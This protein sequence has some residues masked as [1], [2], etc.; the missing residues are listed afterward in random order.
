MIAKKNL[1]RQK[2]SIR[3][4]RKEKLAQRLRS[5]AAVLMS[6]FS[7]FYFYFAL[8]MRLFAVDPQ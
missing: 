1:M 2:L 6:P 4:R 5:L 3:W 7:Q 8:F